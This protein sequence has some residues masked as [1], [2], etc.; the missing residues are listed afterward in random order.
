MAVVT[1]DTQPAARKPR[2]AIAEFVVQQPL[3]AVSFVIIVVMMFAG[4]FSPLVAPYDPL[5]I[6]FASILAAPSWEHWCGTDAYGRDI[7]SRLIYG[8]RTALV[9]GFTSSFVGSTIGAVLGVASAY[10]GGR[11]DNIIQR[12]MD[13]LLAFPLIVLALVVVAALRRFVIGG[14]D[15]NLIFAIAIPIIPRVARVVRAAALSVRVMPYV[16]AARAAGYS[17]G[18]I[19]F[20]HMAP[21][22]VAP[23]LIMLTAFI[24]QAILAEASLSFLGLGVAEP[25]AAWGLMLSGNAADFYREAPWM[26]LFPG[27]AISLAVF[28]FNLF[29]DSLRDFLDPRFKV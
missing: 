5:A 14:V 1:L 2:G 9:I 19:I 7:C 15:V 22:V 24:A 20:R 21:N 10:F 8:S 17:N 18:R 26:I 27:A 6:D 16:D 28:A 12:V 29:G 11:I 13:I 3:G 4:I 23:Y 25:T